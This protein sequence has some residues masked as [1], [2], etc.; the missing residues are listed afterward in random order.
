MSCI[1]FSSKERQRRIKL[2]HGAVSFSLPYPLSV[3]GYFS[4]S[5]AH[6]N[7]REALGKC[8]LF[9]E[10]QRSG[11]LPS[12]QR[13]TWRGDSGLLDGA[14]VGVDLLGGYYDAGDNVKFGFPM[15]F[16][17]TMLGW[18]VAE[19]GGLMAEEDRREALVALRWATD[20]LL[21]T[22][23]HR[24]RIYVQVFFRSFS[25]SPTSLSLS[26]SHSLSCSLLFRALSLPYFLYVALSLSLRLTLFRISLPD[27]LRLSLSFSPIFPL[28]LSSGPLLSLSP[29]SCMSFSVSHSSISLSF[30]F[31]FLTVSAT[32]S[33]SYFSSSSLFGT[34]TIS[35]SL[36]NFLSIGLTRSPFLSH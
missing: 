2:T 20:Y 33:L 17:A 7:Y 25:M 26:L 22:V 13:L 11:Y 21:K 16:T 23:A 14:D 10:G 18:S 12:D 15:A 3:S 1:F 36:A 4:S 30:V 32:L 35:L 27:S 9:F 8:I 5:Y 24:D 6:H 28:P 19:F 31:L 29:I 34:V